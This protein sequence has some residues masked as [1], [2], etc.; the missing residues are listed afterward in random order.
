MK[1]G[2]APVKVLVCLLSLVLLLLTA[3]FALA[4]TWSLSRSSITLNLINEG[5]HVYPSIDR[6]SIIGYDASYSKQPEWQLLKNSGSSCALTVTNNKSSA[7]INLGSIS[8]LGETK[9]TLYCTYKGET[10]NIP[11]TAKV[12]LIGN[13]INGLSIPTFEA[14]VGVPF[15]VEDKISNK[16]VYNLFD[17]QRVDVYSSFSSAAYGKFTTSYTTYSGMEVTQYTFTEGG[18]YEGQLRIYGDYDNGLFIEIPFAVTVRNANG[19]PPS[20]QLI[21]DRS[22]LNA[23]VWSGSTSGG[24]TLGL[25]SISSALRSGE[26]PNWSLTKVSGTAATLD[27][28]R[29]LT[30][31]GKESAEIYITTRHESSGTVKYN[32]TCTYGGDVVTIPVTLNVTETLSSQALYCEIYDVKDVYYVGETANWTGWV[33]GGVNGS[34]KGYSVTFSLLNSSGATVNT[35]AG[36]FDSTGDCYASTTFSQAGTYKLKMTA[37]DGWYTTTKESDWFYVEAKSTGGLFSASITTPKEALEYSAVSATVTLTESGSI[38]GAYSYT[39]H[40]YNQAGTV[41]D[42][43]ENTSSSTGSFTIKTAGV[44]LIRAYVT[45]GRQT[46][47]ADTGWFRI[48]AATPLKAT[49][50][51]PSNTKESSTVTAT[52]APSGSLTG[53][54]TYNYYLYNSAGTIVQQKL[55]QNTRQVSFTIAN[56]GVYLIRTYVSDGYREISVDTKW[57][58]ISQN[59]PLTATISTPPEAKEGSTISATITASGSLTGTYMYNY[60]L[61]NQ[62]G[63]LVD[64][65]LS[66]YNKTVFF[67]IN[68]ADTYLIRA[69]VTDGTRVKQYVDSGW[70]R[71]TEASPLTA[72]ITTPANGI[73]AGSTV[74]ATITAQGS[75]NGW[76]AYNY[77]LFNSAGTVVDKVIMTTKNTVS[78]KI[79][80]PGSYLIRAD[81]TDGTRVKQYVDSGWFRISESNPLTATITTP[82]NDAKAGST[83]S[84]TITAQGS[85]NGWYAYN[86]YLFNS[87]GTVVDKVIMT[88]KNTVSFK[89]ANAGTYLIRADVTDGTRV[90]Q[91]VDSGWFRISEGDPLM[92]TITTPANTIAGAT[93]TATITAQGSPNGWYA[94]NYYLFNSTGTVVD[95][96][97]MTT[98]NT[99][100]FKIANTGVYLIRADVTDGTRVKQY[101]D[102]GWFRISEGNPL[103]A[104]IT[105]PVGATAG[106]TVTATVT[107]SGSPN[108]W[109]AYNY[110]LCNSVGTVINKVMNTTESTVS[111]TIATPGTYMIRADVSDGIRVKSLVDSK[112]FTVA[113]PSAK[114]VLAPDPSSTPV[115]KVAPTPTATPTAKPTVAPTPEP[116]VEPTTAPTAVPTVEPTTAPTAVPTPEPTTEPEQEQPAQ[117]DDTPVEEQ[118]SEPDNT[119][120][121][122]QPAQPEQP[123]EPAPEEEAVTE[124]A[125]APAQDTEPVQEAVAQPEEVL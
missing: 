110:Y 81:V 26:T 86:Y 119:P 88:T 116:T 43:K 100:S 64:Q 62:K 61:Y 55:S 108:G 11:V 3:S 113:E 4:D 12:S 102:S 84:A 111:F 121:Q 83:V 5:H 56:S 18:Y 101:V 14:K 9:Y 94:Y 59:A 90:K 79:A 98:K 38:T 122:E 60:Y 47:Y 29:T 1:T 52:V 58:T 106:S 92:A 125:S 37:T 17:K 35:I 91:Y 70:F 2:K 50:T 72:T 96:V 21:L 8:D 6:V 123:S 120:D 53:S 63:V 69:D 71:I 45:N 109:Y 15:Y 32:L 27:V 42:K 24:E 77:Y 65:Q 66:V 105:T 124:E 40:L 89:I 107:A 73:K 99:V 34:Y 46:T 68:T 117:P 104:T 36:T 80:N 41:V 74:S 76:Y 115:I 75:P 82:A 7:S 97:I 31:D 33:G 16:Q 19:T 28:R 57:F 22:S 20:Y 114:M 13:A 49:V 48:T 25:V 112:W 78:F 67:T 39:Y 95:K 23:S 54:Y 118:P 85:P 10:K 103:T 87:T 51:T 44:Y 30:A 93:V